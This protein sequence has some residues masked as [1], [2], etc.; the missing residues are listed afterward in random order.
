MLFNTLLAGSPNI[1]DGLVQEESP[2]AGSK[3]FGMCYVSERGMCAVGTT[4]EI[5]NHVINSD[6]RMYITNKGV[7]KF[8]VKKVVKETPVLICEVEVLQ[9]DQ[10]KTEQEAEQVQT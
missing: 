4:L 3:R 1:E 6:G 5:Q 7:E 2:F 9:D 8:V 10:Y